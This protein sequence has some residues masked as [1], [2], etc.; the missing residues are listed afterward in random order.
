MSGWGKLGDDPM[1]LR[2]IRLD[3]EWEEKYTTKPKKERT[4]PKPRHWEPQNLEELKKTKAEDY[5]YYLGAYIN[6]K[7]PKHYREG[8]NACDILDNEENIIDNTCCCIEQAEERIREYAIKDGKDPS[9]Y[10]IIVI[11]DDYIA[12]VIR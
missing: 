5:D 6:R 7:V 10:S 8:Y 11:T 2:C 9:D 1:D 4:S 3:A 12:R